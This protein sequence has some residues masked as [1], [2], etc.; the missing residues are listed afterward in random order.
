MCSVYHHN[1]SPDNPRIFLKNFPC[2]VYLL[3]SL[4]TQVLKCWMCQNFVS[5]SS[6]TRLFRHYRCTGMQILLLYWGRTNKVNMHQLQS[7]LY[8][9]ACWQALHTCVV[10][11][12]SCTVV[13]LVVM[14]YNWCLV[15]MC[16]FMTFVVVVVPWGVCLVGIIV[17]SLLIWFTRQRH[18]AY[19]L[20]TM[21]VL[22][23][24]TE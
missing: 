15:Y 14:T 3:F 17:V 7:R 20:N 13:Y 2:L 22:D 21:H 23:R 16:V 18:H 11:T 5:F 24:C 1:L 10:T 4:P 19:T 8:N 12:M 9:Y 6:G